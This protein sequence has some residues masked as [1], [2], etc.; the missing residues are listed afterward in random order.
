MEET[1]QNK[2]Q[3]KKQ[4]AE[5]LELCSWIEKNIF[6]YDDNQKLQKAA[7][8]VLRG[9]KHGQACAN[10]KC[11]KYGD[12]SFKII[13][14]TFKLYKNQILNSIANK[15]FEGERNKMSYICAIIKDKINDVNLRYINS[16][17][18]NEN[19][20]KINTDAITYKGVEY[21]KQNKD[22]NSNK[23]EDL[24]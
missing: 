17:K 5:W 23:F 11:E 7:C 9:L 8:L 20:E 24:W 18:S 4:D 21:H 10:N 13:L 16:Q 3:N 22:N 14:M 1:K 12:Y 15:N 19:I 2:K 6:Q